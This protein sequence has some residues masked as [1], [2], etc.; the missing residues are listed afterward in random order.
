MPFLHLLLN[1]LGTATLY[2]GPLRGV[3]VFVEECFSANQW[4]CA[5]LRI[6]TSGGAWPPHS[7]GCTGRCI[8]R[9]GWTSQTYGSALH[10][11]KRRPQRRCECGGGS[12]SGRP[13][14]HHSS[15]VCKVGCSCSLRMTNVEVQ[16]PCE[17]AS[18]YG[19][20]WRA[21]TRSCRDGYCTAVSLW[22]ACTVRCHLW[23]ETT[24]PSR[25]FWSTVSMK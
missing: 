16:V 7:D 20:S 2:W 11:G 23:P 21:W 3:S 15:L 5:C 12:S 9:T 18:I 14:T 24:R 25:S 1:T 4:T 13:G 10:Q 22:S 8:Y 17:C 6:A 19:P